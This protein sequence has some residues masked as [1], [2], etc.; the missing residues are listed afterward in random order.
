MTREV[1]QQLGLDLRLV[2]ADQLPQVSPSTQ[3]R[4]ALW[5]GPRPVVTVAEGTR[6][7]NKGDGSSADGGFQ[8]AA[9]RRH[10]R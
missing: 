3:R 7:G 4:S 5:M 8:R 10:R 9:Y 2:Q 1:A 6:A